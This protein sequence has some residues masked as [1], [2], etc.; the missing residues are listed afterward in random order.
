M[1]PGKVPDTFF[2]LSTTTLDHN[3]ADHA[4]GGAFFLAA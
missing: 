3:S 1:I 4:G 2:L